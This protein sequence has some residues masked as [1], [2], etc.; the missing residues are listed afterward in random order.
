[1]DFA[2]HRGICA[3]VSVWSKPPFHLLRAGIF[4][5]Y[6]PYRHFGGVLVIR[7]VER[8]GSD[9]IASKAMTGFSFQWRI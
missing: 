5:G 2:R 1:M 8:D 9:R 3:N 4:F 6:N 7:S